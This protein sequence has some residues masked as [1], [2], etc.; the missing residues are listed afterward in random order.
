MC[1][2]MSPRI[3]SFFLKQNDDAD[4]RFFCE[5]NKKKAK[6]VFKEHSHREEAKNTARAR[7]TL[8]LPL[9]L[10]IIAAALVQKK[11]FGG[12]DSRFFR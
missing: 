3:L 9:P 7:A 8:S 10:Q 6:S 12:G 11:K 1:V 5:K 2:M 4:S